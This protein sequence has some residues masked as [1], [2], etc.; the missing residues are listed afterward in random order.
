[1]MPKLQ[2]EAMAQILKITY[3]DHTPVAGIREVCLIA[4]K[5]SMLRKVLVVEAQ[6]E[7]FK[8]DFTQED[9]EDLDQVPGLL[10][11]IFAVTKEMVEEPEGDIMHA[12]A[13]GLAMYKV[14]KK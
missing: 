1:M 8:G 4:P 6:Y 2:N 11:D 9:L 12:G 5:A 13:Q 3:A 10:A 7:Y 14:G